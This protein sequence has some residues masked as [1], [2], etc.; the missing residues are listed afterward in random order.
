MAPFV[1]CWIKGHIGPFR[2]SERWVEINGP[3]SEGK[4][5]KPPETLLEIKRVCEECG[6]EAG[7]GYFTKEQIEAHEKK[8]DLDAQRRT[9][10]T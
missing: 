3:D 10:T 4:K 8:G 5:N 9:A 7:R 6:C 1:R 2:Y